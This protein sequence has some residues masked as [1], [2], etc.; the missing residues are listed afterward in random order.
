MTPS[1][2]D[3]ERILAKIDEIEAEMKHIGYWSPD[4]P[5]MP[6]HL[7]HYLEAP[8]FESWL[9]CVFLPR[10][11]EAVADR[12]L[13]EGSQVGT[14]ALRQYGYH[15]HVPQ[16]QRLLALLNDFDALVAATPARKDD[17]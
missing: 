5:P 1:G 13:P 14:M 8:S 10:A 7:P 15:T 2:D 4:P 6:A 16:A 9:Q 12:S 11:R 17:P 3:Y